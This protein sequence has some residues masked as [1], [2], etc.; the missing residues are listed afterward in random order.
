MKIEQI[1]D[2]DAITEYVTKKVWE[3]ASG[4]G[5]EES[6][7]IPRTDPFCMWLKAETDEICGIILVE[8]ESSAAIS[9]HPYTHDKS[10]WYYMMKEFFKWYIKNS[11]DAMQ[12]INAKVP[13]YNEGAYKL[14][15]KLGFVDEGKC[16]LSFPK[17][18]KLH[19]Q[20]I[21]GITKNEVR[22]V[23]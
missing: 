1:T 5:I 7:F 18:G 21:L 10:K 12:K 23:I 13:T 9:I 19:D 6:D 17:N 14:A 8:V 16:R 4:D 22:E 2:I 15:L 3:H 11:S 20:H